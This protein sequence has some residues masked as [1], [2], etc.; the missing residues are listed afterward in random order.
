MIQKN[1][2]RRFKSFEAFADAVVYLSTGGDFISAATYLED[3]RHRAS[4]SEQLSQTSE[5][6]DAFNNTF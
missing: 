6:F 1:V 4:A 3:V 2:Q 5:L